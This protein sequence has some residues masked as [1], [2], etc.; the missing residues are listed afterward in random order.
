MADLPEVSIVLPVHDAEARLEALVAGLRGRLVE[1]DFEAEIILAEHGS[2]DRTARVAGQ[3]S[4]QFPEVYSFCVGPISPGTAQ[5]RAIA[6]ARGRYVVCDAI[7]L[8][9]VDFIGRAIDRLRL[10]HTDVV[11]GRT[12]DETTQVP[13][14]RIYQQLF[15]WGVG[16][17]AAPSGLIAFRRALVA[18]IAER[19][20]T[21]SDIFATELVIRCQRQGLR[22]DALTVR[23]AELASPLR[24]LGEAVELRRALGR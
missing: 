20:A 8:G 1:A 3:L 19:C 2:T 23:G 22:V 17:E 6:A 9:D 21:D 12:H 4:A 14:D 16:F 10:E 5:R 13:L 18:P 7:G 24:L 11:V 15:R